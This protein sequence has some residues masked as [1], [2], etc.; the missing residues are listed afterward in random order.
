MSEWL[1]EMKPSVIVATD[2]S[3]RDNITAREE[4]C[5]EDANVV[6]S[7]QHLSRYRAECEAFGDALAWCQCQCHSSGQSSHPDRLPQPCKSAGARTGTGLVEGH[8]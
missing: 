8:N 3:I 4:L 5:G 7:G 1:E 6:L 2:G